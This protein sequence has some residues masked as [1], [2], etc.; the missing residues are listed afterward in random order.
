MG[1]LYVVATPIGNLEDIT[2]RALRVLREVDLIA[3]EDTRKTLKLLSH[4]DIHKPLESYHRH[5]GRAKLER[6]L[7]VL[8]ERDVALV[9]EAGMPGISD[10]GQQLIAS[11]IERG[12]PVVPIPGPSALLTAIVA[13]A[14]LFWQSTRLALIG[15]PVPVV[16]AVVLARFG[17][18][19]RAAGRRVRDD[20]GAVQEVLQESISGAREVKAFVR[21]DQERGRFMERVQRL[22]RSRVRQAVLGAGNGA[23]ANLIATLGMTLVL[24]AGARQVIA[25]HMTAGDVLLAIAVL[26]M[27]FGPAGTFVSLFTQVAGALGAADRVFEF[28]DTPAEP[29]AR[30]AAALGR[31]EGRVT[32]E[33]VRFRYDADGPDVLTGIDLDVDPGEVVALVGPS[34]SGKTTLVSLLPRLYDP[35]EGRVLIDGVDV[36]TVTTASLRAQI[37]IVPQEPFLFG[38][39]V[40]RNIAFGSEGA[41]R[42]EIVEAA[43]AANAHEFISAL[44]DGYDTEVGERGARLSVGQKQ[45]LAIARAI[46]R[47]P[48]ILILDEATSAQDSESERLV[49]E[50]MR[51]LMEGRTSFVIAHRLSTV[52]RAD[53]IVVLEGGRVSEVGTHAE[54]LAR[55][56]IYSRLHALQFST[57]E[58]V[59]GQGAGEPQMNTD[60]HGMGRSPSS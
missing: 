39:S 17:P 51:R 8:Q 38:T 11:A 7:E 24:V 1:T 2:L 60:G 52:L 59:V 48:R 3:A 44:P 10:P 34:G 47:N 42:S 33:S 6:L 43:K 4:Y 30:G 45:R 16:F 46:L 31:V 12:I 37:A 57:E 40:A 27:L 26:G 41:T 35:T 21:G 32:F 25:G 50:A 19:L 28:L 20:T 29:E 55:E 36:R 13:T 56:G 18:P 9:S 54:L 22:V 53:R 5:S 49:Q 14:M 58:E 23:A 15:L